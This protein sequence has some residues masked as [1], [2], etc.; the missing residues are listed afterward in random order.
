MPV[1]YLNGDLERTAI[2][3]MASASIP[4]VVSKQK[5]DGCKYA[6]GGTMYASPTTVM[7]SEIYRLVMGDNP[8]HERLER[9]LKAAMAT[10][11]SAHTYPVSSSSFTVNNKTHTASVETN[12]MAHSAVVGHRS[13]QLSIFLLV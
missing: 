2:A 6:D 9:E 3:C 5:L 1:K 10:A 13:L 12:A 11:V 4:I 7:A 8:Y